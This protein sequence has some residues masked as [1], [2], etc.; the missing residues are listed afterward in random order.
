MARR[1]RIPSILAPTHARRV[2]LPAARRKCHGADYH[3]QVAASLRTLHG[4]ALEEFALFLLG[5]LAERAID[6]I[7]GNR[8]HHAV[9][10]AVGMQAIV[11]EIS[12]EVAG[13]I[14]HGGKIIHVDI[15]VLRAELPQPVIERL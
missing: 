15:S 10:F 6:G 2:W 7:D 4:N 11:G 8:R 12:L 5:L 3:R 14:D 1:S 13:G 9:A